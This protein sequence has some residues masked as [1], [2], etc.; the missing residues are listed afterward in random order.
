MMAGNVFLELGDLGLELVILL[1]DQIELVL[2][3]HVKL[4]A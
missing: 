3:L 1:Q 2:Q 4:C